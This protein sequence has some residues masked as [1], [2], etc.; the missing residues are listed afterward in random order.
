VTPING[1]RTHIRWYVNV[2]TAAKGW[3][4][5][6]VGINRVLRFNYAALPGWQLRIAFEPEEPGVVVPSITSRVSPVVQRVSAKDVSL[7][8]P[9]HGEGRAPVIDLSVPG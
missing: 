1:D 6:V 7:R 8:V 2:V 4:V 3:S 5:R 9:Q